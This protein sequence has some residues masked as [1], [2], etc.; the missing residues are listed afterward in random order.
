[1]AFEHRE[2]GGAVLDSSEAVLHGAELVYECVGP[3]KEFEGVA[4]AF[5]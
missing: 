1:M 5:A 4:E 2:S 3:G